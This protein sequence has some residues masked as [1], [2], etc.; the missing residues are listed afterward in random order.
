MRLEGRTA[1]AMVFAAC[2]L[3][4]S[5][6]ASLVTV[7]TLEGRIDRQRREHARHIDSLL[8]IAAQRDTLVE[9]NRLLVSRRDSVPR[10]RR[11]V[12]SLEAVISM[13]DLRNTHPGYYLLIDTRQ[14]RF[15]LRRGDLLVRTGYCGTGKGWTDSDSGIVYNFA[16]PRGL[17][18]VLRTG[19]N[20]YWYRPDWYWIERGM[21]PPEPESLIVIPDSLEWEEQIAFYNDSLTAS[22]RVMVKKVP[23]ALGNYKLD[24]G[25]GIL[26]HY[27]VGR[28]RNSSHGCIRLSEWDLEAI[29]ET[30]EVGDPVVIY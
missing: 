8:A 6:A 22:E 14:N 29:F 28:G 4:V 3:F 26:L 23:G 20:P 1:F 11:T 5:L 10:L 18:T 9:L 12:D 15:Q 17:R 13:T 27:G 21:R 16:T 2:A 25:D 24:L 19:E 30:L 7:V